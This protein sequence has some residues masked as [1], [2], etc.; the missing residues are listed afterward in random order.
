MNYRAR[1]KHLE[2][3]LEARQLDA[4]VVTHL[5]NIHY[6][7]GF[8]G[9]SGVLAF[10]GGEFRFFTDG[11]YTEQARTQVQGA[12]VRV[13]ALPPLAHAAHWLARNLKRS[14]SASSIA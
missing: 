14:R 2:R 1:L 7:C 10:W 8:A 12:P 13:S 9:S 6:L 4:F 11:R 3:Y 5:A